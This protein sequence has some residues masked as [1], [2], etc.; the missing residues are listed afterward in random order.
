[1][2]S[3]VSTQAGVLLLSRLLHLVGFIEVVGAV[4]AKEVLK[5]PGEHL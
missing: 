3:L 2:S 5:E 4:A 1:M